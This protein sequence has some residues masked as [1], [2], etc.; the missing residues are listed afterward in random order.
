[1]EFIA[2]FQDWIVEL[3]KDPFANEV[4]RDTKKDIQCCPPEGKNTNIES[5]SEYKT[6]IKKTL[7]KWP[8]S[9]FFDWSLNSN[10]SMNK[11]FLP[12]ILSKNIGTSGTNKL[13]LLDDTYYVNPRYIFFGLNPSRDFTQLPGI[14]PGD[15]N[16]GNFINFTLASEFD[17]YNSSI[18]YQAWQNIGSFVKF[19]DPNHPI[20]KKALL[21][22]SPKFIYSNFQGSYMTDIAPL[23]SVTKSS[24][25]KNCLKNDTLLRNRCFSMVKREMEIYKKYVKPIPEE[26][27][28]ICMGRGTT[29]LEVTAFA[30]TIGKGLFPG[31]KIIEVGHY[32]QGNH[33]KLIKE[34]DCILKGG[35]PKYESVWS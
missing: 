31:A 17:S 29:F 16:K 12:T 18:L 33:L 6:I 34:L 10:S 25:A 32:S 24:I 1:M 28:I 11:G 2:I 26:M 35:K 15:P 3:L 23:L 9:T 22:N 5:C 21:T 4:I 19:F 7:N 30:A 27:T 13:G 14:Y 20:G 8:Y